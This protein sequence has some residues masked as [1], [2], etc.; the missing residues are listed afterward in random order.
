MQLTNKQVTDAYRGLTMLSN[1]KVPIKLAWK[2]TT[3]IRS[4]APFATKAGEIMEE[5]QKKYAMK[6]EDGTVV[7][8]LDEKGNSIPNTM[9][10][11]PANISQLNAEIADILDQ[12]VEVHNVQLKTTDFPDDIDIEPAVLTNLSSILVT[13]PEN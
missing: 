5:I 8:G 1:Q 4:L 10:I 13:P 6:N 12:L 3:A 2:I 11:P 9:Q 7:L